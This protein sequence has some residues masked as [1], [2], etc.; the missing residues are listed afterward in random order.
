MAAAEEAKVPTAIIA[1]GENFPDAVVGGSVGGALVGPVLL[2]KQNT[3]PSQT[4]AELKRLNPEK[5]YVVGGPAVIADSVV[6]QLKQYTLG[7]VTRLAGSN[8]YATAAAV[9]AGIFLVDIPTLP[10]GPEAPPSI[11]STYVVEAEAEIAG[12]PPAMCNDG[13]LLLS[14]GG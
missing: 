12:V 2:V 3:I 5:I 4:V 14:G 11:L 9:S 6:N 10:P 7:S 1:T 13:D 8:R